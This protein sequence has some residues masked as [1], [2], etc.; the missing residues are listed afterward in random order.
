MYFILWIVIACITA[1]VANSKGRS[2]VAWF[3]LGF[4]FSII[5]L[6]I[7]ALSSDLNK[8]EERARAVAEKKKLVPCPFCREDIR[9]GAIKCKHCGSDIEG[10]AIA[11]A[12]FYPR[13][14][15]MSSTEHSIYTRY[16][17][18]VS[19]QEGISEPEIKKV[20]QDEG[21]DPWDIA[22]L[23]EKFTEAT[24]RP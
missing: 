6:V 19:K 11:V 9:P 24:T 23:W 13:P 18:I 14:K 8:E 20:L 5:A 12:P 4:F 2:G 3:F 15:K 10:G 21:F 16:R 7:V 17:L 1:A 22:S